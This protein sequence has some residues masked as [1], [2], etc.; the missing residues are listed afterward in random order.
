MHQYFSLIISC[1]KNSEK[2]RYL[3]LL[4]FLQQIS[5][6]LIWS[7]ATSLFIIL[8]GISGVVWLILLGLSLK[9]LGS[10]ASHHLFLKISV[11]RF[12]LYSLLSA[13][14][15][16]FLSFALQ[17]QLLW[18]TLLLVV[19]LNLFFYQFYIG[20]SRRKESLFTPTEAQKQLPI[21]DTAFTCG[22]IIGAFA[23]LELLKQ[24]S[25]L[26]V[27]G[28]SLLPLGLM[29][30]LVMFEK[31]LLGAASI[32]EIKPKD[33]EI[34]PQKTWQYCRQNSFL[35]F[36]GASAFLGAAGAIILDI[37][38]LQ[39]LAKVTLPNS[40][41]NNFL[42]T[43]QANT[44]WE[45]WSQLVKETPQ[46]LNQ[47]LSDHFG[48]YDF[49]Q[50]LGWF[51]LL[52][53][54]LA[55][56]VQGAMTAPIVKKIGIIRS[57][58]TYLSILVIGSLSLLWGQGGA[59]V[60]K[61]LKSSFY[62]LGNT[63]YYSVFYGIFDQQREGIRHLFEGVVR[64]LGGIIGIGMLLGLQLIGFSGLPLLLL[65]AL[66]FLLAVLF[67]FPSK[68][69]FTALAA[70]N[71]QHNH[72]WEA[73]F[74]ALDVLSQ[75]GHQKS[76]EILLKELERAEL[77][78]IVRRSILVYLEKLS[79]LSMIP[80]LINRLTDKKESTLIKED[81]LRLFLNLHGI[82][83]YWQSHAFGLHYF[84][85]AMHQFIEEKQDPEIKK[86]A[87][88]NLFKHLPEDHLAPSL[89]HILKSLNKALKGVCL[90]AMRDHHDPG[91]VF[92]LSHYLYDKDP[93]L[94]SYAM[95]CLWQQGPKATIKSEIEKMLHSPKVKEQ[96]S[97]I[98]T[99]GEL[100]LT[101]YQDHLRETFADSKNQAIRRQAAVALAKMDDYLIFPY[102]SEE[103]LDFRKQKEARKLWLMLQRTSP[104]FCTM[105]NNYLKKEVHHQVK[106]HHAHHD[107]FHRKTPQFSPSMQKLLQH[108]YWITG[109][110]HELALL[111]HGIGG[112]KKA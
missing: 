101:E 79:D 49:A 18:S 23:F 22:T 106:A 82:K 56:V 12:L 36:F 4:R 40:L 44:F 100:S 37:Y 81:I 51:N 55:L 7:T 70:S 28:F 10:L 90:Q 41:G 26:T 92:Y 60:L 62:S 77:P 73:K 61:L 30:V 8:W 112:S 31:R 97:A 24:V 93:T 89:N 48:Q 1:L 5:F 109:Q 42:A 59:K 99:I 50:A 35:W 58:L 13:A 84:L 43:L 86:L 76:V 107:L 74:H 63:A 32:R 38:F 85:Q 33:Q 80:P 68:D 78:L 108:F 104:A 17:E 34:T 102:L 27:I 64:P 47:N 75:A 39:S 98:Y 66:F 14:G 29:I 65:P 87:I 69:R 95:I 3:W 52:A 105:F 71:V 20:L 53:G 15:V 6:I 19:G 94:R 88:R 91:L 25:L 57:L 54:S 46:E 16:I 45:S 83:K 110:Y 2:T 21:I 11:Q 96:V 111:L 67:L 9:L 72:N 103:I